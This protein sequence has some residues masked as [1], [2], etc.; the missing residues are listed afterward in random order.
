MKI[1]LLIAIV[2]AAFIVPDDSVSVHV[3]IKPSK[4]NAKP[5]RRD[6]LPNVEMSVIPAPVVHQ[7]TRLTYDFHTMEGGVIV[8][9]VRWFDHF[10][11][12]RKKKFTARI[13]RVDQDGY[14]LQTLY[15]GELKC[16]LMNVIIMNYG[17]YKIAV[18][19][20]GDYCNGIEYDFRYF[21]RDNITPISQFNHHLI[22]CQ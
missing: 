17:L 18:F 7:S 3:N 22:P 16:E 8:R 12:I 21:G 2:L 1:L 6:T 9:N 11:D 5:T 10:T 14:V 4:T 19:Q 13:N 20:V 15:A